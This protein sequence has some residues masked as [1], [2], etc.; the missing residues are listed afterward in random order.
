MA[1]SVLA[2]ARTTKS[3]K[4]R[5]GHLDA[6]AAPNYDTTG[7]RDRLTRWR[8]AQRLKYAYDARDT[9]INASGTYNNTG[10]NHDEARLCCRYS[11]GDNSYCCPAAKNIIRL[12]AAKTAAMLYCAID[13]ELA[14]VE[15]SFHSAA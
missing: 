2:T 15:T 7:L 6:A 12:T 9:R 13:D 5:D 10:S 3:P 1:A 8:T 14:C 4:S 11:C